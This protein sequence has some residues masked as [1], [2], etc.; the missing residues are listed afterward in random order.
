MNNVRTSIAAVGA[1]AVLALVVGAVAWWQSSGFGTG[2]EAPTF[3]Q[4]TALTLENPS[5]L[6]SR[7]IEAIGVEDVGALAAALEEGANANAESSPGRPALYLAAKRGNA[8]AARLLIDAG[9]DVHADTVDG[10]IL[11]TAA[12]EGH[13]EIVEMLL[14]AGADINARGR[15]WTPDDSAL[16]AASDHGHADIA[17]LLVER[18]ADVNQLNSLGE[19]ALMAAASRAH[20]EIV[21]L[22]LENDAQTDIQ[23]TQPS[24]GYG[25]PEWPA[26][27]TALHTAAYGG[28]GTPENSLEVVRLLID[29]GAALNIEDT[30][31][32]TPL[33][34]AEPQIA[35]LL[36]E[37]G[38]QEGA[39]QSALNAQVISAIG[40]GDVSALET[41]LN[42]GAD[43]KSESSPGRPALYLAARRGNA[44]AVSLLIDAG[45]D[46]HADTVDG[47]ILVTAAD[48]GHLEVVKILL[49]AGADI[50]ATGRSWAEDDTA[51]YAAVLWKH[52]E[53]ARLLV[54]RG[55]DVNQ[56]GSLGEAPLIVAVGRSQPDLVRLLLEN[57]ANINQQTDEGRTALHFAAF[58]PN[59]GTSHPESARVLIEYGAALDIKDNEGRTPLDIA[60][61]DV[62]EI[63]R[64]AGA[65]N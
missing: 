39:G 56:A 50:N 22:L 57:G 3:G 42:E 44:E 54:E 34:V 58:T 9:A 17:R 26:G 27:A 33:D 61:P 62:A 48:E 25:N 65:E 13:L 14:D 32:R 35:E 53:V 46:V 2:V 1:L 28:Y 5:E 59:N 51:L 23:N 40:E 29:Y 8:D 4:G 45:A 11:V 16:Y 37:A 10:A 30:E 19:T 36:R 47:A 41:A 24:R 20:P 6:D 21:A 49:D 7:V 63:L 38:A 60:L 18:G 43:P 55:A 15:S 64:A 52:P 31:G 12:D